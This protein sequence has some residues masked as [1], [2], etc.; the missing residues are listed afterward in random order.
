L[1]R[2]SV[3]AEDV[4]LTPPAHSAA[5]GGVDGSAAR[6]RLVRVTT[7]PNTVAVWKQA[8]KAAGFESAANWVRD[9]LAGAHGLAVLRPPAATTIDARAVTGRVL[10]LIAQ[11]ETAAADW[12]T[13]EAFDKRL[14]EAGDVLYAALHSLTAYGG[15]PKARR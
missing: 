14:T 2:I 11:T 3:A 13:G 10:G 12:P 4:R 6:W 9:A 1:E 7:D 5:G 15:D 8:A